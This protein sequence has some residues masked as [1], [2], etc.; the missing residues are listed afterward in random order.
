MTGLLPRFTDDL[1]WGH[2]GL[3]E[4]RLVGDLHQRKRL[5]IER[6]DAVIALPGDCGAFEELFEEITLKRLEFC[7]SPIIRVNTGSFFDPCVEML[8]RCVAERFMDPRY[9]SMW[10]A[11]SAPEDVMEAIRVSPPWRS[12]NCSFAAL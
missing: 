8:E 12:E 7:L 10:T 9:K 1:A 2:K 5:M 4:L 3:I 11:V 6:T